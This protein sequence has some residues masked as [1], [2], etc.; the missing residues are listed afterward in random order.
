MFV[1]EITDGISSYFFSGWEGSD[2]D[3]YAPE[4]TFWRPTADDI[5]VYEFDDIQEVNIEMG[6]I[7]ECH[8]DWSIGL[9]DRFG[10]DGYFIQMRK[11]RESHNDY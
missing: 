6:L 3:P 1:I 8:I 4:M 7:K 9:P 11:V 2:C 5:E 10:D